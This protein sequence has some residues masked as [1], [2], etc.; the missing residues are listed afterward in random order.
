MN[1]QQKEIKRARKESLLLQEISTFFLRIAQEEPKL[2]DLY[3]S[4]VQLSTDYGLCSVFFH[5][6][7]GN[8]TFKEKLPL[9]ILYKPSLRSAIAHAIQSRYTPELLF[10]YDE[11]L[12]KQKKVND[13]IEKLKS[14]G[15]L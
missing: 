6:A 10:K 9:L 2:Q 13:L 7:G 14:E 5:T 12:D 4:R 11:V 3:I 15:K 8:E 1:R